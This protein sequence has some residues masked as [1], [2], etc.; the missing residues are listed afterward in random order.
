MSPMMFPKMLSSHGEG[1]D[2]LMKVHPSVTKMFWMYVVP[3]SLVPPAMMLYAWS[4][5]HETVNLP[6][7]GRQMMMGIAVLF[8][9]TEMVAV[10]VM[11][12]IIQQ[13]GDVID[14]RP[15]YQDA[16]TLA[17]VAPTPLWIAPVAFFAPSLLFNVAVAILALFAVGV[18]IYQG[19]NR[20]FHMGDDDGHALLLWGSVLAAGLCAWVV[21]MLLT[22]VALGWAVG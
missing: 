12:R 4:A 15:S 22:F 13:L 1:W 19:V 9:V 11:A 18:L 7:I 21:M 2:W 8:Y 5:Y 20:V 16:F 3:M 17:A 14:A 10:P 6:T